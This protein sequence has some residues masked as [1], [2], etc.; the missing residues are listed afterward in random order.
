MTR[1]TNNFQFQ[2]SV[3]RSFVR[4]YRIP[5]KVDASR[6]HANFGEDGRL[7]IEAPLRE[8]IAPAARTIP[9]EMAKTA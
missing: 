9:I 8:A 2:G 6:L 7:K 1:L 4:R 5:K 3:H